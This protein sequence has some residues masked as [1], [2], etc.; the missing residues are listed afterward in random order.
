MTAARSTV[1]LTVDLC[2][3]VYDLDPYY[4]NQPGEN[5]PFAQQLFELAGQEQLP[6]RYA[7]EKG[8]GIENPEDMLIEIAVEKLLK[9]PQGQS[10]MLGYAAQDAQDSALA[11][12]EKS[13]AAGLVTPDGTPTAAMGGM[14]HLTGTAP[15]GNP[16]QQQLAGIVGGGMQTQPINN[17]ARGVAAA[18]GMA[19]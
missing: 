18:Q 13:M 7:L 8:L 4:P 14:E 11:D 6:L 16:A 5:L 3:G 2:D 19:R 12:L 1:E 9:M 15:G 17:D 10:M